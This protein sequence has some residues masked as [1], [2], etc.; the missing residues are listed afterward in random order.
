VT[1]GEF[2]KFVDATGYR[3]DAEMA[4]DP[5]NWRYRTDGRVRSSGELNHPVINVSWNDAV[6][7]CV[8]RSKTEGRRFALP[9][10]AQWEYA[11]RAGTETPFSTGGNL[12]T[13][14]AN[15]DGSYP[16]HGNAKGVNRATTTPVCS[17]APNGWGLCDMHGN[18]Y[19]WCSDWYRDGYYRECS[20]QGTVTDPQGIQEGG[21]SRVLR[22][23]SWGDSAGGCRSASRGS[24]I[25][26]ARYNYVGFRLALLP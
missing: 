7:Y 1:V 11:C 14:E 12:T 22:G 24:L 2:R 21:S 15:Y 26:D 4:G 17:F 5:V 8:W 10:E 13:G 16:Y 9:T 3:T 6:A 25:P 20:L 18:V 23:G 19:E